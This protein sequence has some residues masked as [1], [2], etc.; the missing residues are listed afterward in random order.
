[1]PVSKEA[2]QLLKG[3]VSSR[4]RKRAKSRDVHHDV[5]QRLFSNLLFTAPTL[6]EQRIGSGSE[7]W[8][9]MKDM[10]Y[11]SKSSVSEW[12][13]REK[14]AYIMAMTQFLSIYVEDAQDTQTH[15]LCAIVDRVNAYL[16]QGSVGDMHRWLS[17]TYL[18]VNFSLD[19]IGC[20]HPSVD[21]A[22]LDPPLSEHCELVSTGEPGWYGVASREDGHLLVRCIIERWPGAAAFVVSTTHPLIVHHI[23]RERT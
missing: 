22:T 3:A 21:L 5:R 20:P 13:V 16:V 6:K 14:Q 10:T 11:A 7:I 12:S 17:W 4:S 15:E 9:E 1:M 2:A 18:V 8:L 23:S 19:D